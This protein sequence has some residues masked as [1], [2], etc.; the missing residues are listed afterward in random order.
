MELSRTTGG[1]M[2]GV[3]LIID[4]VLDPAIDLLTF[5]FGGF[6]ADIIAIM[7]FWPW[8]RQYDMDLFGANA[9]GSLLTVFLE[10]LP[11]VNM[12]VPGWTARIAIL[13]TREWR[14]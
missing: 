6:L 8:M 14:R 3:A 1:L 5:G 9:P 2:I 4:F 7:I 10:A 11:V 13:V 12:F